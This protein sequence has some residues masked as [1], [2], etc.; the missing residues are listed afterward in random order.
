M[1]LSPLSR[2]WTTN[3]VAEG[4]TERHVEW[5]PP[6]LGDVDER[7]Y[8]VAE[9]DINRTDLISYA[10]YGTVDLWWMILYHNGIADPFSLQP[11]DRIRIP[12]KQRVLDTLAHM[13]STGSRLILEPGDSVPRV[14]NFQRPVLVPYTRPR[15]LEEVEEVVD[16]TEDPGFNFGFQMPNGLEGPIH[17]QI[18]VSLQSDFSS[19]VMSRLTFSSQSRWSFYNPYA[20]DQA[21]SWQAFPGAG[22]DGE[23]YAGQAI[24]Y[25][26]SGVD[27]MIHGNQ[28]YFRYRAWQDETEGVWYAP[29]PILY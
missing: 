11:G 15:P 19:L 24:Y 10:M 16:L 26:V 22:I 28:Y 7:V 29:P 6:H 3:R 25:H 13:R 9:K 27:P 21:G 23:L 18:E 2:F 5:S 4:G 1:A 12:A 8:V 20:N 14:I 17:F